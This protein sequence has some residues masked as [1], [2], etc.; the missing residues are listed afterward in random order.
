MPLNKGRNIK[1][2][3][4]TG[5]V[6]IMKQICII[7]TFFFFVR[8]FAQTPDFTEKIRI[9][10]W[11]ELDAYP[12]LAEAQDTSSGQFDYPIS[13]LK[14]TAPFLLNGMLY[15]WRFEYTPSDRLRGVAEYFNVEEINTIKEEDGPITYTKPWFENNRVYCWVEFT[16]TPQM[17][18]TLKAWNSIQSKKIQGR[19]TGMIAD[20][21]DGITNAANDA[22]KNAVREHYRQILKNKPKEIDGHVI[23]RGTP[24]IGINAGRYVVELDFFLE[25]DRIVKYTQF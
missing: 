13:R 8:V 16:R 7:I 23:I 17:I 14:K 10:L 15:G 4:R 19:G 3:A 21:F 25:T 22:L 2:P 20:G 18:W 11:A 5:E 9:P 24:Q 1:R 6:K 12:E